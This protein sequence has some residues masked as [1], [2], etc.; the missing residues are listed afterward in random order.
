M[1]DKDQ[2]LIQKLT[3]GLLA[4]NC[5]LIIAPRQKEAV[6]VDPGDDAEHI[7]NYLTQWELKPKLIVATHGHFDHL[8]AARAIQLAYNT[9]FLIHSGDVFLLQR[10]AASAKRFLGLSVIDPPPHVSRVLNEGDRINIGNTSLQVKHTPGHTPGSICL[11]LRDK[12]V[13]F[14]GDLIFSGGGYGR[15]D[16]VYSSKS[17]LGTSLKKI[18]R[19]PGKV[20]VFPGHGES[21]TLKNELFVFRQQNSLE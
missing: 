13:V 19:L 8:L 3:V 12:A 6:I 2:I 4:T 21:T 9:P 18:F 14:G 10:M 7:T 1:I 15:T 17:Q 5:Y 16:F 20:I 11:Y